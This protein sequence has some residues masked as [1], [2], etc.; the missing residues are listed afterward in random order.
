MRG[1]SA[2]F[3][4]SSMPWAHPRLPPTSGLPG[5]REVEKPGGLSAPRPL[6][7][8][9]PFGVGVSLLPALSVLCVLVSGLAFSE[10]DGQRLVAPY[11]L[12]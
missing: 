2:S 9:A 6:H 8:S 10:A 4:N 1:L 3:S 5:M 7:T 11:Q 12:T